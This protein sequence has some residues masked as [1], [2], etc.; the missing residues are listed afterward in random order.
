[1]GKPLI[2]PSLKSATYAL[3]PTPKATAPTFPHSMRWTFFGTM[4]LW[5]RLQPKKFFQ[6]QLAC[7][8]FRGMIR[9]IPKDFVHFIP[10]HHIVQMKNFNDTTAAIATAITGSSAVI[11]FAQ[12][13]QP[14]VTFGVGILG[15]ISGI[16]AVI[17]WAKKIN[18]IK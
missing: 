8:L 9:C 17:Y 2:V 12:I 7:I 10:I 4:N 16:L 13:Y 6:I 3:P 15:I 11:T 1:M 14:L 18:R 5:I